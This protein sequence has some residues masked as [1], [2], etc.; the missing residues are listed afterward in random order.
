MIQGTSVQMSY[1]TRGP[2]DYICDQNTVSSITFFS[3]DN[4]LNPKLITIPIIF[5]LYV[6]SFAKNRA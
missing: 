5:F 2:I 4:Q 3:L 1:V 6:N